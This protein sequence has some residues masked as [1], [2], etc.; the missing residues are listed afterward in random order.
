M[1]RDRSRSIEP[2]R[3]LLSR[4]AM[5]TF[6]RRTVLQSGAAVAAG[7]ALTGTAH[8]QPGEQ[9]TEASIK[10]YDITKAPK[11]TMCG[12]LARTIAGIKAQAVVVPGF[13]NGTYILIVAGKKPNLNMTVT[14]VPV[15]YTKQPEYWRI[16]VVAC[17]PGIVLP[18]IGFYNEHLSLDHYRGTKGIE[19]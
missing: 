3:G 17:Q 4:S 14:L 18:T 12:L 8:A 10:G 9:L 13:V 15:V 2:S 16:E 6:S 19:V 7:M 1:E 11:P 5:S